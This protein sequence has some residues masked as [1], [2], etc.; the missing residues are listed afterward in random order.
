MSH[1][2]TDDECDECMDYVKVVSN[3]KPWKCYLCGMNEIEIEYNSVNNVNSI[4]SI[5]HINNQK[6]IWN[7]YQ[8]QCGDQVHPRC[9]RRWCKSTVGC[10]TIRDNK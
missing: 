10:Q 1:Y 7:R 8:L 4:N 5:N 6:M 3:D 9:Y 2:F